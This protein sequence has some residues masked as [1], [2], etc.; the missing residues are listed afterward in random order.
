MS[1][2]IPRPPVPPP[3]PPPDAG[4]EITFNL[5]KLLSQVNAFLSLPTPAVALPKESS[6]F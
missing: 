5:S 2:S 3:P 6:K 4:V 1:G